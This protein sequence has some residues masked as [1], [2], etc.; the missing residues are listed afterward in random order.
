MDFIQKIP[1][2]TES[3][4]GYRGYMDVKSENQKKGFIFIK[5]IDITADGQFLYPKL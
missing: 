5:D 2:L 3:T 4:T 1:T